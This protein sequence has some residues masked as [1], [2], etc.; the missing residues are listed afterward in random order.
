[1]IR[2][3]LLKLLG[4]SVASTAVV[5]TPANA[6]SVPPPPPRITAK[7]FLRGEGGISI[8]ITDL[9]MKHLFGP[10]KSRY[11][12]VNITQPMKVKDIV[13]FSTLG[14]DQMLPVLQ[15]RFVNHIPPLRAGDTLNTEI[16]LELI[17]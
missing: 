3:D 12:S 13:A 4:L 1:M 14:G 2:R 8:D 9:M 17:D 6:V 5:P 7:W 16:D 15:I 10:D 11:L